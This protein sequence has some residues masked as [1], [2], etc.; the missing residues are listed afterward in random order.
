MDCDWSSRRLWRQ[1]IL[2]KGLVEHQ[3]VSHDAL[4]DPSQAHPLSEDIAAR[5]LWASDPRNHVD[6]QYPGITAALLN[7]GEALVVLKQASEVDVEVMLAAFGKR[8]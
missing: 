5:A 8:M 4:T 2:I 1:W 6:G 7:D 3:L